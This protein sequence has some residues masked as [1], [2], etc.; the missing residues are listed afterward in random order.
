M[1]RSTR[2]PRLSEGAQE[3][4]A[5]LGALENGS[6]RERDFVAARP[7]V[8]GVATG[9]AR[10]EDPAGD[11]CQGARGQRIVMQL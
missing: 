10:V 1:R 9:R 2:E 5:R 11:Y 8:V 4:D 6:E 7:V 3:L